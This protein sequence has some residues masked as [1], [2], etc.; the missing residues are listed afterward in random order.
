MNITEAKDLQVLLA[1]ILG[2][3][4]IADSVVSHRASHLAERAHQALS[5]GPTGVEIRTAWRTR[6]P[7]VIHDALDVPAPAL[8]VVDA[9][10][11]SS[12]G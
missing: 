10:E 4:E 7:V 9:G 11:V 3:E 12:D 1:W 8:R 6:R 5:T 2:T